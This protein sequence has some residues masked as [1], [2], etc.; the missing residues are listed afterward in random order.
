MLDG[1]ILIHHVLDCLA[2]VNNRAMIPPSEGT[3]NFLK[4]VLGKHS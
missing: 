2:G 1:S 3:A 4:G